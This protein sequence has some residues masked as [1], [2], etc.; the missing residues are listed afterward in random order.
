MSK[1]IHIPVFPMTISFPKEISKVVAFLGGDIGRSRKLPS[2]YRI[3]LTNIRIVRT[4]ERKRC[5]SVSECL[6]RK[7]RLKSRV[8]KGESSSSSAKSIRTTC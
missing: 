7:Y 5:R 1:P 3:V 2:V 8:R 6:R 4:H